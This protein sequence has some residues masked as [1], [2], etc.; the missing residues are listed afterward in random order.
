MK[1][2]CALLLL[3]ATLPALAQEDPLKSPACGAALASLQ[4]ARQ[5]GAGNVEA[6]RSAAAGACLGTATGPSRPSRIAQSPVVVPPPQIDVPQQLA[7][8]PAPMMPPPPV[9]IG[10][11][12]S[13]ATCDAG[14]CWAADGTHLRYIP[15]NL[16][17]PSGLCTQQGG[18]IYCP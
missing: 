10:R 11:P 13:P 4:S 1:I 12:P 14:G 3:V 9:A 15:P 8:L 16:A 17:G 5:A 18:A 7:P 6:L 2:A